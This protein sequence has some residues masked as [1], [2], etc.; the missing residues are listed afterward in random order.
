MI[1]QRDVS[2]GEINNKV[3][4]E[5]QIMMVCL[6]CAVSTVILKF[7]VYYDSIILSIIGKY[8]NVKCTKIGS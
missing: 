6:F 1:L 4:C 5:R 2:L 8:K 3:K 7:K